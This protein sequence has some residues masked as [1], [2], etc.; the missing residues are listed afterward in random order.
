MRG[1]KP[2]KMGLKISSSLAIIVC[3]LLVVGGYSL[4]SSQNTRNDIQSMQTAN[5][6][7]L[8]AA[9]AENDYIGA[10]LEMQRYSVTGD[11]KYAK[12]FENKLTAVQA[13]EKK[14]V[15]LSDGKQQGTAL[16]L[17][18]DTDQYMSG[19]ISR[20]IPELRAQRKEKLAGNIE[21]EKQHERMSAA[22]YSELSR[23]SQPIESTLHQMVDNNV[24][25]ASGAANA[26]NDRITSSAVLSM[27]LLAVAVILA[28]VLSFYL[29]RQVTVPLKNI[30]TA[31]GEMAAGDFSRRTDAGLSSRRDEFGH[32]SAALDKMKVN[33]KQLIRDVQLKAEQL[34]AASE[35]LSASAE[36]SS[37]AAGQVTSSIA[38]VAG[39]A[40]KQIRSV[41]QAVA[42]AEKN[43]ID[44]TTVA[45]SA[46]NAD[47]T[48][49][50]TALAAENGRK[51][52]ENTCRQ[53]AHIEET[54]G[55]SA[56]AVSKLG[57]RSQQIGQIIDTISGI[58]GQTNLLALNAAIEAARAGEQGRGFAV[59]ADEVRKLA[60]QSEA[61][62]SK[63]AQ[64]IGEI[65]AETNQAVASMHSGAE[66]VRT[67]ARIVDDAGN[68]FGS[69]TELVAEV[70]SQVEGIAE[71]AQQLSAGG[72]SI[73]DAVR[74]I[75]EISKVTAEQTE[76]VSAA[77]EEQSASIEEI[78][79]T[80][81]NLAKMAEEL[82]DAVTRFR[83]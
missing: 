56:Q 79:A 58:A 80:S 37:Q 11:E 67:G 60:E 66:E 7:A 1:G 70:S 77:T 24:Q 3:L 4:W 14:I 74:K 43:A 2:M 78:A 53:M 52:I 63:I 32:V 62:A 35:E 19:A 46:K 9:A 44:I 25:V 48:S 64:L 6:L 82:Q 36:Q 76:T 55:N 17:I 21:L 22:I 47:R 42:T 34:S 61:A 13:V 45:Q 50:Q 30:V 29:T 75:D 18:N 23:F 27:A 65:Q 10:V 39:G 71:A 72:Q 5:T 40:D 38:E 41:D 68:A 73:V 15:D 33:L 81:R 69:I 57:E 20:L 28:S 26:A 16:Q 12:N 8:L 49:R 31:L 54:V 83:L 59:V 51:I